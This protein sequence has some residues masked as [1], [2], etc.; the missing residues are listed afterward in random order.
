[1]RFSRQLC[2]KG[3]NV[4]FNK[5]D[6]LWRAYFNGTQREATQ[7]PERC[8]DVNHIADWMTFLQAFSA[9]TDLSSLSGLRGSQ[10]VPATPHWPLA[11]QSTMRLT[12]R[13]SCWLVASLLPAT[14]SPNVFAINPSNIWNYIYPDLY[15]SPGAFSPHTVY[16]YVWGID[17]LENTPKYPH[18]PQIGREANTNPLYKVKEGLSIAVDV[19][20]LL[21]SKI[22]LARFP[23]KHHNKIFLR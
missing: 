9:W 23:W 5:H 8:W 7:I 19:R 21:L 20:K 1:M 18:Q 3:K 4:L 2:R 11:D 13:I 14:S 15:F 17:I 6:K 10:V 12:F 22:H 16:D